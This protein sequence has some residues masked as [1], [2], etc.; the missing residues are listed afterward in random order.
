[1]TFGPNDVTGDEKRR[2]TDDHK[3]P[4]DEHLPIQMTGF[5]WVRVALAF[6]IKVH[7]ANIILLSL[8]GS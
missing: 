4:E 3:T 8:S 7:I 2:E 6:P 5:D 1:M